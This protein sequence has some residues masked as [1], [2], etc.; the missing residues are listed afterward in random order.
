MTSRALDGQG[1]LE[2]CTAGPGR[3]G[4]RKGARA[5]SDQPFR[6]IVEP[7]RIHSVEPMRL[8]TRAERTAAL[9][10]AG[11]NLFELRAELVLIDLL[12]DSGTGAMSAE[13]WAG[14]Q[15][16]NEAYAGAPSFYRFRDAVTSLFPFRHVLP[17]HQGRAAERILFTVTGGAGPGRPEQHPFRH[18]AGQRR[19]HRGAGH[20]PAHP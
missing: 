18:D 5:I 2:S 9:A 1:P 3:P 12:T 20:R 4:S 19:V 17:T 10:A 14:I 8:T 13:Q 7:F 15:R 16:G 11:Y 6:T